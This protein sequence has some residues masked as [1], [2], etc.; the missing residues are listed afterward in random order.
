MKLLVGFV[1][2]TVL[3]G[4]AFAA[5]SSKSL[6]IPESKQ[7]SATGKK[8]MTT[9]SAIS[10]STLVEEGEKSGIKYRFYHSDGSG[11]VAGDAD[12]DI[13]YLRARPSNWSLSC[14]QDPMNDRRSCSAERGDL[15]LYYSGG[16]TYFV[17]ISGSK[18][19]GS[20]I[21]VRVDDGKVISASESNGFSAAQ[22]KAI[23][24]SIKPGSKLATRYVDWPY[25]TNEDTVSNVYGTDVVLDYL[26][27]AA[28]ADK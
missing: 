8:R 18:Y 10:P 9:V 13:S 1:I 11:T 5:G 28:E 3:M 26:K 22:S 19:P 12:N 27:W 23:L 6:F 4:S 25:Q 2:A 21:S 20:S 14:K 7:F 17:G 15:F 16:G 24:N